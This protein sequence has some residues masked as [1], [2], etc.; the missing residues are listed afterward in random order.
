M[1]Q[2]SERPDQN[3]FVARPVMRRAECPPHRVIDESAA[4][5]RDFRHDVEGRADHKRG[6]MLRFDDVSDE[7]DGLVAKR[8]I[9]DEQRQIHRESF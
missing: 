1:R 8:S 6:D 7:T 3:C 4:G 2:F 9:G 5:R